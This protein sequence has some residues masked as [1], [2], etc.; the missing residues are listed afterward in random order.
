MQDF[1]FHLGGA[2]G[3]VGAE[4]A[5]FALR[6]FQRRAAVRANGRENGPHSARLAFGG[7]Y[8]RYFG[9]NLAAFF[10]IDPVSFMDVQAANLVLVYQRGALD[11]G[12]AQEHGLQVGNG[13]NGTGAA[14]L[15]VDGQDGRAG[16]LRLEFIRH[17]PAGTLGG[18]AQLLLIGHLIDFYDDTVRGIG[19]ILPGGIPM[20]NK[21]FDFPDVVA[22][23]PV[24]RNGQPP[25]GGRTERSVVGRVVH[26]PGRDVVEGAK[27]AP[28]AHLFR[29]L[30]FERP[31]GRITRIGKQRLL[32][33]LTL[34]VKLVEG[35][36]W[37]Q[38]LS[39]YLEFLRIAAALE[40]VGD[41]GNA[42]GIGGDIVPNDAIPACEG[43][44]QLA[45]LVGEANGRSVELKF[46]TVCK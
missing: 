40:L 37:H 20:G 23:A 12:T 35:L 5:G 29:V 2:A 27:E 4:P 17:G 9:D 39:P 6:L 30:Q 44:C 28:P 41:I 18:I 45:V 3:G 43:A 22:D 38:D 8:S 24:R 13:R 16:L 42:T 46:T 34:M 26:L 36:V 10:Y 25:A 19:Q 11:H 14:H 7:L 1:S 31:A 21:G 33:Y 32:A 15:I